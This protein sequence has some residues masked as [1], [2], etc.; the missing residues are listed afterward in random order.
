M[1]VSQTRGKIPSRRRGTK[2]EEE[3]GTKKKDERRRRQG[4]GERKEKSVQVHSIDHHRWIK[5]IKINIINLRL[6]R[7]STMMIMRIITPPTPPP[8]M[9]FYRLELLLPQQPLLLIDHQKNYTDHH[10][11]SLKPVS[12]L[13][14]SIPSINPK[15]YSHHLIQSS[16]HPL[17]RA[18]HHHPP[19]QA[20]P[21]ILNHPQTPNRLVRS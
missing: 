17:P 2:N 1:A 6:G 15:N 19:I 7:I 21:R 4:E 11:H 20:R 18:S 16:S 14:R 12:L 13:L 10:H 9:L 3:G 5:P 8:P